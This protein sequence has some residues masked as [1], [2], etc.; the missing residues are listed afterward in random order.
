MSVLQG[1]VKQSKT[2][3]EIICEKQCQTLHFFISSKEIVSTR[4]WFYLG[5]F[6][7]SF[8]KNEL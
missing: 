4:V 5:R 7:S 1:G 2:M 8:P 6:K 3:K